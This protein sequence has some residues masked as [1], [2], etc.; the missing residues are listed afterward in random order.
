MTNINIIKM[1]KA[2][3]LFFAIFFTSLI[4]ALNVTYYINQVSGNDLNNG[5]SPETAWK[6]IS[7]ANTQNLQAGDKILLSSKGPWH[8]GSLSF[9]SNDVGTPDNP[10]IVSSYGPNPRASVYSNDL[11]GLYSNVGSIKI[12]NIGFYGN[13]MYGGTNTSSGINFYTE[14]ALTYKPYINIDNCKF[15]GYGDHGIIIDSWNESEATAK[16]FSDITIKNTTVNNCGKTGIKI[17]SFGAFAHAYVHNNVLIDN[18]RA[19]NNLGYGNLSYG[20]GSGIVVSSAINVM[21]QNCVANGNGKNNKNFGGGPAGI[22]MYDVKFGTIQ[23]CESFGNFAGLIWDGNGFG[24]DGGCQNSIIQHCYSHDNE[25]SGYG[26]FEFGSLNNFTNNTIRFNI[27]QNDGRKNG[28]GGILLWALDDTTN[29]INNLDIYN[30]TVYLNDKNLVGSQPGDFFQSQSSIPTGVEILTDHMNNVRIM[31][32]I[33]YI[34]SEN[35]NISFVNTFDIPGNSLNIPP[36]KV[37]MLNNLYHKVGS[38]PIFNWGAPYNSLEAW[39]LATGQEKYLNVNYGHTN[40]PNLTS[41]GNGPTVA[42]AITGINPQIIPFG[43][44]VTSVTAYKVLD[45]SYVIGKGLNLTQLFGINVGTTDFYNTNL[46]TNTNTFLGA[47]LPKIICTPPVAVCKPISVALNA[48]GTATITPQDLNN[49]SSSNCGPV[50]LDLSG[51]VCAT[52]TSEFENVTLTAPEGAVF[53][54]IVFA[55]YGTPTGE[56]GNYKIGTCHATNTKSVIESLA[57]GKNT[58]SFQSSNLL[59]GGPC[60]GIN[61]Q[62]FIEAKYTYK[63]ILDSSDLGVRNYTLVVTDIDGKKASCNTTVTVVDNIKPVAI[64]KPATIFLNQDGIARLLPSQINNGSTDNCSVTSVELEGGFKTICATGNQNDVITMT[65][66]QGEVFTEIVF[67]S[68][69]TPTGSC[70]SFSTSSCYAINSKQIIEN[71]ALGQNSFSIPVSNSVFGDP[72]SGTYKKLYIQARHSVKNGRFT[73]LDI[74]N[75]NVNLVVKDASGNSNSC[76]ATVTVQYLL[77]PVINCN[78]P[79]VVAKDPNVRGAIPQLSLHPNPTNGDTTLKLND[80]KAVAQV[81]ITDVVMG[82]QLWQTTKIQSET[83][84][85]VADFITGTYAVNVLYKNGERTTLK[86]IK[87]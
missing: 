77:P 7:R 87:L 49:G 75:Q 29:T 54:E 20:S 5:T 38:S 4:H 34:E 24:L 45:D 35:P 50:T 3:F 62:L 28:K 53:T 18:V 12:S 32:N 69:G 74:G 82:R 55:S 42:G 33:F 39:S 58:F 14:G 30:N 57:L 52:A 1:K 44:D 51:T 19:S 16:G 81:F 47:H 85:P 80:P 2:L 22:W 23:K 17:G 15:E 11:Q 26:C 65:A 63:T 56:C 83:I 67:A 9:D 78:E 21:I 73:C 64:C 48:A 41:P 46:T 40:N 66:P 8:G 10:I 6:T 72:C 37:L 43:G 86:L 71:L 59:F 84:L 61:M 25:G 31:N 36:S 13:R 79:I 27:S 68:Y 76:M 60:S 70:E